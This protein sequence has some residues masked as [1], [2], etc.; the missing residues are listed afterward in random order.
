M[1]REAHLCRGASAKREAVCYK[2]KKSTAPSM[3][4]PNIAMRNMKHT[5]LR[6]KHKILNSIF[7]CMLIKV[8]LSL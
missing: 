4:S 6:S 2:I 5:K 7:F 1:V 3:R 8:I